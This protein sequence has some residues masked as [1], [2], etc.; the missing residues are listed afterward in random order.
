MSHKCPHRAL[1]TLQTGDVHYRADHPQE[2][3][4]EAYAMDHG[5]C[6]KRDEHTQIQQRSRDVS[7]SSTVFFILIYHISDI[8]VMNTYSS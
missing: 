5:L 6:V 4:L 7:A 1:G 2:T 3:L 8:Q